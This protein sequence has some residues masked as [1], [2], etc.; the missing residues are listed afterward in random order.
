[1]FELYA[2]EDSLQPIALLMNDDCIDCPKPNGGLA[3]LLIIVLWVGV[4]VLHEIS[5][6]PAATLGCILYFQQVFIPP[7]PTSIVSIDSFFPFMT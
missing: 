2:F 6:T 3:L 4:I 7:P 5:D 1:M